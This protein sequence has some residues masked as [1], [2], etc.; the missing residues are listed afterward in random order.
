MPHDHQIFIGLYDAHL[1]ATF[2][3]GYHYC[4]GFIAWGVQVKAQKFQTIADPL[5]NV[6]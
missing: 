6:G 4:V 1:Y 3:R 5:A 2:G